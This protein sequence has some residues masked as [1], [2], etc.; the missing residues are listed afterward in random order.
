MKIIRK[1]F[2]SFY[3]I[4][5]TYLITIISWYFKNQTIPMIYYMAMGLI[6]IVTN[7]RRVNLITLIFAGIINYR[8]T[9]YEDNLLLFLIG[10][11]IVLPFIIYDLIKTKI[12]FKDPILISLFVFIGANAL[13]LININK[14]NIVMGLIGVGQVIIFAL[15]YMYFANKKEENDHQIIVRNAL[16][17]S[18]AIIIEFAIYYITFDGEVIGK[19]IELGW[20]ISNSIAMTCLMLIPLSF[21]AYVEKQSRFY[22]LFIVIGL[23]VVIILTLCKG[24]YL[25][26]VIIAIPF[27]YLIFRFVQNKKQFITISIVALICFALTL[28]IISQIDKIADGL[29]EYLQSMKDR[30]WFNDQSRKDIYNAGFKVFKEYPIFGSGSYTSRYYL[31]KYGQ[32]G[33]LHYHNYFIQLLATLGIVGLASFIYMIYQMIRNCWKKDFYNICVIFVIA[34]MILHG[35]VDN[36]WFNP[37][38]PVMTFIA[39]SFINQKETVE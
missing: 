7:S 14:E 2:D 8:I 36:T 4:T 23:V 9:K 34:A 29:I 35:L 11:G 30:G 18:T 26:I 13:S 39:L 12:N 37:I 27:G 5:I 19:N 1:Y 24:A 33:I 25:A 6:I 32:E 15:I 22:A 17:L 10:S 20:G 31:D 3:F 38:V 21:H 16:F 28:F